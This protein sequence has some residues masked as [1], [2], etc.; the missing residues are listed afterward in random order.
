ML[1]S[2]HQLP[3]LPPEGTACLCQQSYHPIAFNF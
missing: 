3:N 2:I 1:L